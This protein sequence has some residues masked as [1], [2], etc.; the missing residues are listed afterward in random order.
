MADVTISDL[1]SVSPTGSSLL[2]VSVGGITGKATI[3][4]LPVSY[5]SLTNI[6]PAIIIPA[7]TNTLIASSEGNLPNGLPQEAGGYY[8]NMFISRDRRHLLFSGLG[9]ASGCG[10]N[11]NYQ[12][13]MAKIA[14][15]GAYIPTLSAYK[16]ETVYAG[17]RFFVAMTTEKRIFTGGYSVYGN[18]VAPAQLPGGWTRF[19]TE[20]SFNGSALVTYGGAAA[21]TTIKSMYC[22]FTNQGNYPSVFI[23]G[24]DNRLYGFGNTGYGV[25]MD[26]S[27]AERWRVGYLNITNVSNIKCQ[28][29]TSMALLTDGTVRTAGY[30]GHYQM[31]DGTAN[32]Y[33]YT[34][35][36]PLR[37]SDSQPLGSTANGGSPVRQIEV[38]GGWADASMYAVTNANQL[39][40]WGYNGYYQLGDGTTTAVQYPKL[41]ASNVGKVYVGGGNYHSALYT[42]PDRRYLFAAGYSGYGQLNIVAPGYQ[43]NWTQILDANNYGGSKIKKV[44]VTGTGSY[45]TTFVLLD[46]SRILS[47]GYM[48]GSLANLYNDYTELGVHVDWIETNPAINYDEES[49]ED[50]GANGI[51]NEATVFA[52]TT[53]GRLHMMGYSTQYKMGWGT[54]G[55]NWC[56]FWIEIH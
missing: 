45:S 16:W 3:S 6:P 12:P 56:P 28:G 46:N 4:T 29:S 20:F 40:A 31:G 47:C 36:Q 7:N 13:H 55:Y 34:W 44:I 2:P 50:I 15:V 22:S 24:S 37:A 25:M 26:T 21:G 30:S 42:T 14:P 1:P 5:N 38:C 18:G 39:Y 48:P 54:G 17:Y 27:G 51:S 19:S 33:N 35:H 43:Y 41:V 8:M 23:I 10:Y 52:L 53:K 49:I 9:D 11:Y 32:G